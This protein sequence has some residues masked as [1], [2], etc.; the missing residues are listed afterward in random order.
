MKLD[1]LRSIGEIS[2]STWDRLNP[3]GN[4]FNSQ[5]FLLA[6]ER[7]GATAEQMGWYPHHIVLRDDIDQPIAALPLFL[8][9]HSFGDFSYDWA[10]A[11]AYDRLGL[12][13]YP[14]LVSVSPYTPASGPRFLLRPDAE[15][16]T[17][18][19]ALLAAA[20]EYTRELDLS[21]WQALYLTEA[22]LL[23][24]RDA[25]LLVRQGSQFHWQNQG[26]RDF[27]DFLA[28]FSADKR[29]KVKR[30][31]RRVTEAGLTVSVRHGNEIEP[32]QWRSIHRHY[33]S[34]FMQY[35]N[36]AAFTREFF[37]E[38]GQTLGQRMVLFLAHE[39]ERHIATA[40]CYRDD[41]ALY[42]R[43]WGADAEYHSLH[44]ELCFYQGIDYCIRHGL[45]RFEPGAQG[46]HKLSRGF[47]PADTWS[48]FWIADAR[49]R[50]A[51]GDYLARESRAI[52]AYQEE[53]AEHAPYK[54]A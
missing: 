7:H 5:A 24:L 54:S 45:Q 16:D 33:A 35:G 19:P 14:K 23:P 30:E 41:H 25:G 28:T 18:V 29:K 39:G 48:A 3:D 26:Y 46:E 47:M 6:A 52:S 44:F 53:M 34:T 27:E 36:H 51:I 50:S 42:G 10:W 22:D 13:Y 20:I 32:A 38:V 8:R 43:H 37:V 21:C 40:I 31:R 12:N 4:P 11:S 9:T 1:I 49:M 15:R 17:V 2:A